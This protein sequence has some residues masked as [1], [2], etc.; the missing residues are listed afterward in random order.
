M[1]KVISIGNLAT[2]TATRTS[3]RT[4]GRESGPAGERKHITP[5][6]F[7]RVLDALD[8][9]SRTYERDYAMF[10]LA[11]QHGLR[12]S[13]VVFQSWSD[14]NL[15]TREPTIYIRRLKGSKSGEH[16]ISP[17]EKKALNEW[18]RLQ[19]PRAQCVFTTWRN[20]QMTGR[21]IQEQ[22][23]KT[24]LRAGVPPRLCHFHAL[25][26]GAGY[27]LI[28]GLGDASTALPLK[29]LAEWLGHTCINN[30]D[31][32]YSALASDTFRKL[33]LWR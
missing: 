8:R 26:H 10:L 15:D 13:E 6:E 29:L 5:D 19:G 20:E 16:P 18:K 21:A 9:K 3:D 11:Y 25:R 30:T 12:L 2:Q 22:F 32:F 17:R 28:N 31:K 23:R 14:V 4:G 24:A 7:R 33:N 27:A 1:G